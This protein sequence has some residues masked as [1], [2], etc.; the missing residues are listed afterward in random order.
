MNSPSRSSF[1]KPGRTV[2]R[3]R[4]AHKHQLKEMRKELKLTMMC[5]P[6]Q[7]VLKMSAWCTQC[8]AENQIKSQKVFQGGQPPNLS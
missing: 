7:S 5:E 3:R 8:C 6:V 4:H 1:H 2:M